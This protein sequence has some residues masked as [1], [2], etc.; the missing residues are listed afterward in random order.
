MSRF[1]HR[2]FDQRLRGDY[3]DFVA[4]EPADVAAWLAEAREFVETIAVLLGKTA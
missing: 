2:L 4:F 1:Y 3:D